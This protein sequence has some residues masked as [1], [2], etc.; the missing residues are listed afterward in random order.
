MFNENEKKSWIHVRPSTPLNVSSLPLNAVSLKSLSEYGCPP[1]SFEIKDIPC[2][3]VATPRKWYV[4]KRY[5]R[6]VEYF[7]D[8]HIHIGLT[9]EKIEEYGREIPLEIYQKGHFDRSWLRAEPPLH[10]PFPGPI[11]E[12]ELGWIKC[13]V[14]CNLEKLVWTYI[15]KK[16]RV[17]WDVTRLPNKITPTKSIRRYITMDHWEEFVNKSAIDFPNGVSSNT[18]LAK[19]IIQLAPGYIGQTTAILRMIDL[20]DADKS[21]EEIIDL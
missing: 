8:I 18:C 1:G 3:K 15:H 14:G 19:R 2:P 9:V 5:E 10:H 11:G 21:D 12:I 4:S 20:I 7:R 6:K 16:S 13:F 17:M